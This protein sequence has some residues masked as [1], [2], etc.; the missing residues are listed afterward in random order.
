V[1]KFDSKGSASNFF[2]ETTI[3]TL[4]PKIPTYLN[5]FKFLKE[6]FSRCEI[7]CFAVHALK[8]SLHLKIEHNNFCININ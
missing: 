4:T 2:D 7:S 8:I 3:P 1:V 5:K 6:P